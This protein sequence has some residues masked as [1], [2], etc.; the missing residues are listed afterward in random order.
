VDASSKGKHPRRGSDGPPPR[1]TQ[2]D[3]D[4][5]DYRK[6]RKEMQALQKT[7]A[8]VGSDD[9]YRPDD[10]EELA[11]WEAEKDRQWIANART[12]AA[13]AG[14]LPRRIVEILKQVYP[15]DPN[16]PKIDQRRKKA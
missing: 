5:R 8:S 1:F 6:W 14:I 16:V 9:S 15:E 12:A 2:K 11:E 4:E 7:A 13:R 10:P 3:F